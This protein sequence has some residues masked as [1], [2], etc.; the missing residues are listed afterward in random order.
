MENEQIPMIDLNDHRVSH[1]VSPIAHS[2]SGGIKVDSNYESTVKADYMLLVAL[3][4]TMEPAVVLSAGN[5]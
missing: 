3:R 1:G 2:F 5:A 4:W